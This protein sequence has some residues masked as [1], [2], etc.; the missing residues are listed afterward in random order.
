MF[1]YDHYQKLLEGLIN[2]CPDCKRAK[3]V[4][5]DVCRDC[6]NSPPR[7]P[8]AKTTS[9]RRY[10][11]EHS[12]AWEKGDAAADRFF[13]YI[14][15]LDGGDFYA[16]QTRELREGLSEHRDGRVKSTSGKH[17]KLVWFSMMPTREEATSM[18]VELKKLVD[19]NPREIRRMYLSFQ[20]LVRGLDFN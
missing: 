19:S 9:T 4:Q 7:S 11:P 6:Y 10:Q 16:G 18:E 12:E 2:E 3:D 5:Y 8:G 14:L 15:K 13:I 20:D 17:P 1:C